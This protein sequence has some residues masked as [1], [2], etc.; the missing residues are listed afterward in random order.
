MNFQNK[1]I[2]LIVGLIL[3]S[4]AILTYKVNRMKLNINYQKRGK[5]N[6]FYQVIIY[7]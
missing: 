5:N 6:T 2:I 7:G 1:V 3:F 4:I